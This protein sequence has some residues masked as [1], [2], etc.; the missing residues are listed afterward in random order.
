MELMEFE[1]IHVLSDGENDTLLNVK[2]HSNKSY[3]LPHP[4]Q[5]QHLQLHR[6]YLIV[7]ELEKYISQLSNILHII[8]LD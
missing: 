2:I 3:P 4:I 5:M 7:N 6:R 1:K 8:L